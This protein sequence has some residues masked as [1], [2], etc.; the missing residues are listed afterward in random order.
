[1][2]SAVALLVL[3]GCLASMASATSLSLSF[4][5][6]SASPSLPSLMFSGLGNIAA[7]VD[8]YLD[9]AANRWN[10]SQY[11]SI[12]DLLVA[13][14]MKFL[15]TV[16]KQIRSYNYTASFFPNVWINSSPPLVAMN[17][18]M[19]FYLELGVV[20]S[21]LI[22][23]QHYIGN[24]N[25][26][27][28]AQQKQIASAQWTFVLQQQ[29]TLPYADTFFGLLKTIKAGVIVPSGS[30]PAPPT[31]STPLARAVSLAKYVADKVSSW[32]LL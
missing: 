14:N 6:F 5:W 19:Q 32:F 24:N 29:Q 28:A 4:G 23:Y 27:K 9:I 10:T 25:T 22:E 7:L 31:T 20:V 8:A 18:T 15:H 21:A 3:V 17:Q 26:K 1:M 30:S 13:S 16:R 12:D 11:F 2:R